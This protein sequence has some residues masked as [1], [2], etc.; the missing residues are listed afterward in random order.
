MRILAHEAQGGILEPLHQPLRVLLS[1]G[2]AEVPHPMFEARLPKDAG[3]RG[4]VDNRL[5]EVPYEVRRTHAAQPTTTRQSWRH[6]R[7]YPES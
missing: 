1:H 6:S 2:N 5:A 4:E 3:T 7:I